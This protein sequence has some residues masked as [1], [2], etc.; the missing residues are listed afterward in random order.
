[1]RREADAG[2]PMNLMKFQKRTAKARGVPER[3]VGRIVKGRQI[4]GFGVSTLFP[5]PH[6]KNNFIIS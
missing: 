4:T 6:R 3:S 2:V 5:T 1:M